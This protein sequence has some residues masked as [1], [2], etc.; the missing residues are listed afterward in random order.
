[1][2]DAYQAP[3]GFHLLQAPQV[4]STEAHIVF[5]DSKDRFHFDGTGRSQALACLTGEVG[6]GLAAIFEQAEAD[7]D[8]AVAL[9]PSAHAFQW[10]LA[11]GL[12]CIN[13]PV[14][15]LGR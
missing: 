8:L 12:A 14:G 3:F 15:G 13:A 5:D 4:E 7:A 2:G 6:S 1:M 11:T 9:C 10:A